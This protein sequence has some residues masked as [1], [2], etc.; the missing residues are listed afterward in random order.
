M[1]DFNRWYHRNR[2]FFKEYCYA[3]GGSFVS[4]LAALAF[5]FS[6]D[7]MDMDE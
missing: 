2:Y 4:T 7:M 1:W 5:N 3:H 6:L